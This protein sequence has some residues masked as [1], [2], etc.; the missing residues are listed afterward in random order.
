[1]FNVVFHRAQVGLPQTWAG[2]DEA[3]GGG[4]ELCRVL[5]RDNAELSKQ[6]VVWQAK[7]ETL[8]YVFDCPQSPPLLNSSL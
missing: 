7:F 1:M 8:Q 2:R 3:R 5:Q 6:I 4:D